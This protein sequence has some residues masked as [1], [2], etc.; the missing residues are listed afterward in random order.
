MGLLTL[1]QP[2]SVIYV[3]YSGGGKA[4]HVFPFPISGAHS[5][6]VVNQ[7]LASE[8]F[9]AVSAAIARAEI[10]SRRYT[11]KVDKRWS[12]KD[13]L[14]I[15][16]EEKY[17]SGSNGCAETTLGK[18]GEEDEEWKSEWRR[19]RDFERE[20]VVDDIKC[21]TSESSTVGEVQR[22][23]NHERKGLN[24]ING[25]ENSVMASREAKYKLFMQMSES[26]GAWVGEELGRQS[27]R[28]F[29]MEEGMEGSEYNIRA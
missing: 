4:V 12:L 8:I 19:V 2:E 29:I 22:V 13:Y 28:W 24:G 15:A 25:E 5:P 21:D 26:W 27:L 23:K 1:T 7:Q 14:R 9:D 18:E 11:Y 3:P 17:L 10:Y 20:W 16:A 6:A